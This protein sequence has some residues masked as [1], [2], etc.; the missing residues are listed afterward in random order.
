[1]NYL[2]FFP[3]SIKEMSPYS[4]LQPSTMRVCIWKRAERS[5]QDAEK[6]DIGYSGSHLANVC[7][8]EVT[9]GP[10]TVS[11]GTSF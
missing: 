9:N 1:M 11:Q 4:A 7:S 6:E 8:E 10:A 5:W 2:F 3:S